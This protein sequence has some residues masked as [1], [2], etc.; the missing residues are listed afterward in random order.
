MRK[1][2]KIK[3][4]GHSRGPKKEENATFWPFSLSWGNWP[5]CM[6]CLS[7]WNWYNY[8]YLKMWIGRWTQKLKSCHFCVARKARKKFNCKRLLIAVLLLFRVASSQIAFKERL[9]DE[10][11]DLRQIN[12]SE[13]KIAAIQRLSYNSEIKIQHTKIKI[14]YI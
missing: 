10:N 14:H 12:S 1:V 3:P 6:T 7:V 11:N 13:E 4:F 9:F 5:I 2:E 8:K